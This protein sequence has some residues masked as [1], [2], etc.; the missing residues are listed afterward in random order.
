MTL[1]SLAQRR[2]ILPHHKPHEMNQ[3]GKQKGLGPHE[4][5]QTSISLVCARPRI[6]EII[7]EKTTGNSLNFFLMMNSI[8][9]GLLDRRRGSV[10]AQA[11]PPSEAV[12]YRKPNQ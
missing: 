12:R 8:G 11:I 3:F 1:A 6:L 10:T 4:P 9:W 7:W 5:K 2:A